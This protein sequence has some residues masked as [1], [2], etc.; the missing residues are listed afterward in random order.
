MKQKYLLLNNFKTELIVV[1]FHPSTIITEVN[2]FC[3][4]LYTNIN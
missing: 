1:F 4:I 2:F 3:N